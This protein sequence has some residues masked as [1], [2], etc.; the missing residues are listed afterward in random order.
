[1]LPLGAGLF[2]LLLV[3]FVGGAFRTG[4]IEPGKEAPSAGLG[5]PSFVEQVSREK[6]PIW[7][8]AVGT[9]RSRTQA[10]VASQVTGRVVEVAV[11][12][13][14]SVARGVLIA[15]LDDQEFKARLEQARSALVAAMAEAQQ[16]TANIDRIRKL[17]RDQAATQA[18]LEVAEARAKAATAGVA[19]AQQRVT[20]AE[21][22][23]G[24]TR[25]ESPITG[26]VA[27]REVEPG[28]LAWPGKS[29]FVIQHQEDLRLEASVREGLIGEVEIGQAVQV[30]LTALNKKVEGMI[31]EVVPSAD[32]VSRSFLVKVSLPSVEGRYPGMFGKLRIRRGDRSTVLIPERAIQR[33]G[34]LTTVRVRTDGR[35]ERRYVTTGARVADR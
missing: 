19:A 9:I 8:E 18:Q 4:T 33:V 32:P 11:E 30:D 10:T 15:R 22:S 35:W 17:F 29:L 31:S 5:E 20:E 28:D 34:Q 24:Y 23:F 12:A 21:V 7:Y 13:G 6:Q 3:L 27:K 1:M 16:A 26:V 2:L 25:I 14:E